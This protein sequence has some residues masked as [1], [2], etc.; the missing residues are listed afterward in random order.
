[1]ERWTGETIGSYGT[2]DG[3]DLVLMRH[4]AQL[5]AG[6]AGSGGRSGNGGIAGSQRGVCVV[7]ECLHS[8]R[9][10]D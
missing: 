2:V 7:P 6:G 3:H 5:M 8:A 9:E 1:L 4:K 10:V